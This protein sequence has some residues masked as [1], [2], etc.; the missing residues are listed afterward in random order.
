MFLTELLEPASASG[1][2]P[3]AVA[4]TNEE[5]SIN[6]G[7]EILCVFTPLKIM[8]AKIVIRFEVWILTRFKVQKFSNS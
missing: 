6:Y 5:E 4:Q 1:A 3:L 7:E 8:I 2:Q